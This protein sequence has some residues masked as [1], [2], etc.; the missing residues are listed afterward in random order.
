MIQ[1]WQAQNKEGSNTLMSFTADELEAFN[2][3][4][5]QR[6]LAHSKELERIF[7]QRIQLMR[8]E[9][10]QRLTAA[11]QDIAAQLLAIEELLNQRT[12]QNSQDEVA[13][14][15]ANKIQEFD[16]IEVQTDLPWDDLNDLFGKALDERFAV[17]NETTQAAMRSWEHVLSTRLHDLQFKGQA[18]Q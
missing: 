10:E 9:F 5:E 18:E 2:T 7:D 3:I 11:Q 15:F 6:L 16:T 13:L 4:L 12:A 14:D 1:H 17:L 8:R